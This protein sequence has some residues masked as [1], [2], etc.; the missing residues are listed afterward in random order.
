MFWCT[1]IPRQI[2][3]VC[4]ESKFVFL[5]KKHFICLKNQLMVAEQLNIYDDFA[6][7]IAGLSPDKILAYHAP[8]RIQKRVEY[9]VSRK[10]EGVIAPSELQ[11]L[12][13][14]F[15]FEHIVRLA[16]ARALKLLAKVPS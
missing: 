1:A 2:T 3:T 5:P 9:L 11:E 8:D 12:E 14:Y 15:M 7:F 10:K 4:R 6:E 13:K 16:K